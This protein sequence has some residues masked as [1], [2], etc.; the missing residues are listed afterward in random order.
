MAPQ[1]AAQPIDSEIIDARTIADYQRDGAVCIRGAFKGWVDAIAAG[2]ERN[3][4][5]RSATASDIAGGKGSFFDDYC[6]WERIP[7]FVDVVRNSPAARLAAAVMQ[8]RTAQ[9]FHDHVLVKEPGTQKPTPWHQDIPYYFVDGQQTVSFWIP[10]DPVKEATLRL[11]AGSHKW[12]KMILPVRWLDDGNFYAA[13]GDYRPVPDPDIDPSMK[14]IEWEMEPGDAILFDFRTAHGAR[15]N[16]TAARRRA[17]S[18]RWVGDDAH[19]VERP[20]RTSPPYPGHGMQPGQKLRED[21][22]PVVFQ[23]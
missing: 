20:G 17:L 6:N 15:G 12:D 2:I 3:M 23:G 11:I 5:S 14:V 13:E 9:F 1:T 7:E 18:L 19:Y 21:W 4:R 10:I 8:S 16:M 22:F